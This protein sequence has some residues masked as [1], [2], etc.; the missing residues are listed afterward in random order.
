MSWGRTLRSPD[1][2]SDQSAADQPLDA[3]P[4]TVAAS[5]AGVASASRQ[6]CSSSSSPSSKSSSPWS[7][8]SKSLSYPDAS[9]S[10]PSSSWSQWSPKYRSSSG[11]RR[12]P[13][14]T[15]SMSSSSAHSSASSKA[16][17]RSGGGA[18]GSPNTSATPS[19]RGM[20]RPT[21]CRKRCSSMAPSSLWRLPR[22][23]SVT[24][25]QIFDHSWSMP[26]RLRALANMMSTSQY[27]PSSL[28]MFWA[29][30]LASC[31]VQTSIFVMTI[32]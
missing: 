5:G 16:C 7:R 27:W 25:C 26:R 13:G 1:P 18:L 32:V 3:A 28:R 9:V 10:S 17:I 8:P 31:R 15:G 12:W 4:V 19:S 11:P 29:V 23:V 24:D 30:K 22:G 21:Y 20:P 14:A 6:R 2:P